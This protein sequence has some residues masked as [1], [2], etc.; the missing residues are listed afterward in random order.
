MTACLNTGKTVKVNPD[1]EQLKKKLVEWREW[2][3]GPDPHNIK[4]QIW[5]MIWDDAVYRMINECRRLAPPTL[6]GGVQ[7]NG[8][9]H[10]FIDNCH[11]RLQSLA[12]R[13]LMDTGTDVISLRR[14]LQDI[15]A[16]ASIV[17][18]GSFFEAEGLTYDSNA[19]K[20]VAEQDRR[21]RFEK[22]YSSSG[23]TGAYWLDSD[24]ENAWRWS[25]EAHKDFDRF[26][27]TTV[28]ARSVSDSL[29]PEFIDALLSE[30][31]ICKGVYKYVNKMIAHASDPA[32]RNR[33][34][35][36]EISL[37]LARIEECE[38]AICRVTSFVSV[39]LVPGAQL[40]ALAVPQFDQFQYIEKPWINEEDVSKLRAL[41]AHFDQ[42]THEWTAPEWPS[43]W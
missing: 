17:T 1:A 14:L 9:I 6:D 43:G 16:N 4:R 13:R 38:K 26:S 5:R 23:G 21:R 29:R 18:R 27:G 19:A 7:L 22:A 33:L 10:S 30:L 34:A 31:D 32:S 39:H 8:P 24:L 36:K 11:F 42:Q 20:G 3:D 41:W 25:E 12:I 28:S 35:E 2:M 37:S 40:T 15:K